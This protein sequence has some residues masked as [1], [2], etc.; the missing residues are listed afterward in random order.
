MLCNTFDPSSWFP[1]PLKG[2]SDGRDTGVFCYVNPVIS[3]PHPRVG[4]GCQANQPC[5]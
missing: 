3:G 1:K 2:P 4:A 5:D